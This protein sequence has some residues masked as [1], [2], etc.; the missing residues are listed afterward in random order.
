[1]GHTFSDFDVAGFVNTEVLGVNNVGDFAGAAYD[2]TFSG[3]GFVSIGGTLTTFSVPGATLTAAY[4][5]NSSNQV[6]GYYVDSTAH[7]YWRDSDETLHFPIDP[8]G[9]VETEL[10]GNNDS[11]WMVG[12]YRDSAGITHGLFFVPPNRFFTFDYPGSTFTNFN[13]INSQGAI[14]GR[15][16]E[17]ATGIEHGIIAR[18][19]IS[20][21]TNEPGTEI[22][23]YDSPSWLTPV[24]QLSPDRP[25]AR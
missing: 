16:L 8:P 5:L 2:A 21:G 9:S 17:D 12:G 15:Y 18:V 23:A 25:V 7:G 22:K 6:E 13:G 24:K 3:P 20:A 4:Q 19:R 14:C 1:M 11:N 10:Y